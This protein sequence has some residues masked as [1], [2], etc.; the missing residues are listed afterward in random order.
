MGRAYRR[1]GVWV[2]GVRAALLRLLDYL[3]SEG[4]LAR[5]LFVESLGEERVHLSRGVVIA[6]A[7]QALQADAPPIVAPDWQ[8]PFGSEAVLGSVASVLHGRRSSSRSRR[9]A[10]WPAR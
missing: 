3:D 7:A 4:W 2:D 1:G 8:A 5:F 9:C 10:P 6:R